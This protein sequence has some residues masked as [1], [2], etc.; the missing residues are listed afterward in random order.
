MADLDTDEEKVEAIKKWWKTNGVSVVAGVVIGLGAVL[1][2]R[3]WVQHRTAVGQHAS[4]AFE[5]LQM[6]ANAGKTEQAEKEVKAIVDDYGSTP[7]AMFAQLTAARL[8]V[9]AG[10]EAAAAKT[11][12]A[13]I[14]DAP[15]P[16]LAS[17]AALRLARVQLD[18]GD[19]KAAAATIDKHAG[20]KAF[21]GD[22]AALRGDI[23]AAEGRVE[24]A[25]AAYRQALSEG[26][27]N[28]RLIELKLQDLPADGAS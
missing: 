27:G 2:W 13:A 23:A 21:A 15:V 19:L 8:A 11:L 25:R 16:A 6:S 4:M 12:K 9:D 20:D 22:F 7:Y 17:L 28:V 3:T 5:Q 18:Q 24:D 1:G 14:D 26:A 10:D